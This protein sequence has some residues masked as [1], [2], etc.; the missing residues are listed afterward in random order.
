MHDGPVPSLAYDILKEAF[1]GQREAEID[2]PLWK[3]VFVTDKKKRFFEAERDAS[4]D[5]L[6]ET[7]KEELTAALVKVKN[8]GY[9][10]TWDHVH[11]DP[12][13]INAW[14]RRGASNSHFMEYSELLNEPDEE[15]ANELK[16]LSA[17][18]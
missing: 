8:W 14:A 1:A 15:Y 16:F 5:I 12:A 11:N 13:Y 18:L 9:K 10:K 17:H 6:S 2:S 4:D 7:D 3:Y